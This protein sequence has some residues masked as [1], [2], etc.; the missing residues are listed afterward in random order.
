MDGVA[1]LSSSA[2]EISATVAEGGHEFCSDVLSDDRDYRDGRRA[3]TGQL[4]ERAERAKS[5]ASSALESVKTSASGRQATDD[6]VRMMRRLKEQM[7]SMGR[8][9]SPAQRAQSGH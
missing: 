4:S 5:V 7:G 8:N 3:P 1:V 2:S 9:R 6:T